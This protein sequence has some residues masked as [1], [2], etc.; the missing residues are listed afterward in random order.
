VTRAGFNVNLNVNQPLATA[1]VLR[2]RFKGSL[3]TATAQAMARCSI[4]MHSGE[5]RLPMP[6]GMA[7]KD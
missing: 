7:Y 5:A 2:K 6:K 1:A 3:Q 4:V